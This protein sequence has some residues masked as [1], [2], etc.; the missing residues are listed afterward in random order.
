MLMPPQVKA[1]IELQKRRADVDKVEYLR[2]LAHARDKFA[3][4]SAPNVNSAR[5]HRVLTAHRHYRKHEHQH[6]HAAY[7]LGQEAST[8]CSYG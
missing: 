8:A 6:A 2:R 4:P 7:P 3:G 1:A 5:V